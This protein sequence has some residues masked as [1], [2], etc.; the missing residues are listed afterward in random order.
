[1][2]VTLANPHVVSTKLQVAYFIPL[3]PIAGGHGKHYRNGMCSDFLRQCSWRE[4][5]GP[6]IYGLLLQALYWNWTAICKRRAGLPVPHGCPVQ[7]WNSLQRS[8]I[9]S[10]AALWS[11]TYHCGPFSLIFIFHIIW[12]T[13]RFIWHPGFSV[14]SLTA[15]LNKS[16]HIQPAAVANI[17]CLCH[18]T[19]WRVRQPWM[20]FGNNMCWVRVQHSLSISC[21]PLRSG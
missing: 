20:G 16:I 3:Y 19:F 8:P 11:G 21:H 12:Q 2:T 9:S 17:F 15:Y 5:E 14:G 6:K 4:Y 7:G 10:S 13:I 18:F 1:M